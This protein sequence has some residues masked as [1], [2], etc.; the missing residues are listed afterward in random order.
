MFT[1]PMKVVKMP[2]W[3]RNRASVREGLYSFFT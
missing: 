2:E 1:G 3:V